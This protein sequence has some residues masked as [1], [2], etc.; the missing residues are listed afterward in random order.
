MA[1]QPE[2]RKEH[3]AH[4]FVALAEVCCSEKDF[5]DI[6]IDCC[7]SLNVSKDNYPLIMHHTD[8][9]RRLSNTVRCKEKREERMF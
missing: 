1:K 5:V 3:V 7:Y 8:V 2:R 9:P 6:F 4:T